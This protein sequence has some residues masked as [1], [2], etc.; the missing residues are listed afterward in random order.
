MRGAWRKQRAIVAAEYIHYT[1]MIPSEPLLTLDVDDYQ[2]DR[3]R[4]AQRLYWHSV[5]AMVGR[6]L[7]Y[8]II[9]GAYESQR[10]RPRRQLRPRR[11]HRALN[12]AHAASISPQS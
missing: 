3:C 1:I 5:R 7:T 4:Q 9:H 2:R 11:H 8:T 12:A 10:R 6:P